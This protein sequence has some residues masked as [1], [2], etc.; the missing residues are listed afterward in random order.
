MPVCHSMPKVLW[1]ALLTKWPVWHKKG[2]NFDSPFFCMHYQ[3]FHVAKPEH[4]A[5]CCISCEIQFL[6]RCLEKRALACIQHFGDRKCIPLA[7]KV[8]CLD[9][10][11]HTT[12]TKTYEPPEK[13]KWINQVLR[14]ATFDNLSVVQTPPTQPQNGWNT[15]N[16]MHQET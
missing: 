6:L 10:C 5:I 3:R 2:C 12:L 1:N 11:Q 9:G 7:Y 14:L 13:L 4:D 16:G 15:S 8:L